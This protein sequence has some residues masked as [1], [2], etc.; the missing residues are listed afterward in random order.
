MNT[1]MFKNKNF[2][3]TPVSNVFIDKYMPKANG[4]FVKVYLLGLKYCISGELGVNSSIIAN[5][6]GLLQSDVMDALN[7]W[8]DKKV[9]NLIP[10]DD[11]GNYTI[12]FLDLTKTKNDD[13][14][15]NDVDID[16]QLKDSAIKGMIKDIEKLL[17]R[18]LSYKEIR[19]Y[20]SWQ[21][22]YNFSPEMILLLIQFCASK[23]KTDYRYIEKIALGW[24]DNGI[25]TVEEA[26]AYIK[27][28]EDKWVKI[29]KILTY[30]GMKNTDVMKPQELLFDK[31]LD[32]Y[33][34]SLDIIYKACDICFERLN[35][36]DF[37]Y[38]DGILNKWHDANVKTIDDIKSKSHKHYKYNSTYKNS[39]NSTSTFN[40]YKQRDYD[41]EDLERK[42]LG[43]DEDD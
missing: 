24:H 7:Y 40:N 19:M 22:E 8:K 42:L 1:F 28:H 29:K 37:K 3:Y 35:K 31:W 23:Y 16:T 5:K 32:K 21:N 34:F 4:K 6:L 41:Y 10:I 27:K 33:N 15:N 12:E 13:N 17:G 39:R 14:S 25:K 38:I 36:P 43:W 18:P 11:A 30:L 2:D 9:I 26:Q 20:L